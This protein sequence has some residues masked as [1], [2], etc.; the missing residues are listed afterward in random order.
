MG[1]GTIVLI[2]SYRS[3]L[4]NLHKSKYPVWGQIVLIPSYRSMLR[5]NDESK[6]D[7][8]D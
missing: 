5:N 2:P 4:R 1:G 7:C 6:E 8:G 3:M